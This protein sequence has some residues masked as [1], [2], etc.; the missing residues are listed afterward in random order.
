M[1]PETTI[2][3]AVLLA[4]AALAFGAISALAGVMV[5][6]RVY[7]RGRAGLSPVPSVPSPLVTIKRKPST[8]APSPQ[9]S[10][11][12]MPSV[13]APKQRGDQPNATDRHQG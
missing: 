3:P 7:Q 13:V 6:A 2:L 8:P 10:A 11:V 9:V 5:G 1:T 4:L 12:R